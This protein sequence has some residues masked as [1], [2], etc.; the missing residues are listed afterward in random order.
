M[1]KKCKKCNAIKWDCYKCAETGFIY[2][3]E[4]I[5][6]CSL[7]NRWLGSDFMYKCVSC[8]SPIYLSCIESNNKN[9]EI[10]FEESDDVF[11]CQSCHKENDI[12][13]IYCHT[14]KCATKKNAKKYYGID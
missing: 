12:K 9:I 8:N 13:S 3:C 6:M 5:I 7:C 2:C 4:C 10:R 1:D 14:E 11:I